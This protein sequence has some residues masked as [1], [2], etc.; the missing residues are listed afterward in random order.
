MSYCVWYEP[1]PCALIS[2]GR[3][4]TPLR[5]SQY[6]CCDACADKASYY[7]TTGRPERVR[8]PA[9]CCRI[10]GERGNLVQRKD[11][12][13][14]VCRECEAGRLRLKYRQSGRTLTYEQRIKHAEACRR[15]RAR[16][17]GVKA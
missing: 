6:F 8:Y 13:E 16:Q 12:P 1:R 3:A 2:C 4:F 17:Q 10:C 5:Q 14:T 15:W 9:L 7:R 11:G